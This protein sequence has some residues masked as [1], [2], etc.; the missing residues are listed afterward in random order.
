MAQ[1]LWCLLAALTVI[2]LLVRAVAATASTE[3]IVAPSPMATPRP[4]DCPD[5][6]GEVDI[7]YPYGIG[8]RC[9]WQGQYYVTCN[10]SFNPPR[11]YLGTG[12]VE[13]L[14]ISVETG[15]MRVLAHMSSLCYSSLTTKDETYSSLDLAS[16]TLLISATQNEFTAIGCNTLAQLEGPSYSSGCITSCVSLNA[17]ATAKVA[18]ASAAARRPSRRTL[19][20]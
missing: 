15:D 17:L 20:T 13:V 6:C 12:N 7:P 14:N 3:N 19:A 1:A 5:R 9:S 11:P 2:S 16:T 4:P 10:H 8:E 18:R